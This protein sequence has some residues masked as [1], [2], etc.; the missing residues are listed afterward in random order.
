VPKV[1]T[2]VTLELTVTVNV[3]G[4]AHKPGAGVNV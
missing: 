4:G 3:T 2:G 1:K